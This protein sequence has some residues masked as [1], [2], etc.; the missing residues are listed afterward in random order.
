MSS[1]SQVQ[2]EVLSPD[3][4]VETHNAANFL[5]KSRSTQ[6]VQII[7]LNEHFENLI[8]SNGLFQ[9]SKIIIGRAE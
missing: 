6:L 9:R 4:K 5:L 8:F 3:D 1:R 7:K 2:I